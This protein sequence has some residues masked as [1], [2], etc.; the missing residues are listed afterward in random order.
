MDHKA[1]KSSNI[2][3]VAYDPATKEME[4]R[5]IGGNTYRYSGVPEGTH[6]AF[7][8]SSSIGGHFHQHI[9]DKFK[10]RKV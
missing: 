7:M 6:K 3:S 1:V 8:S 10:T 4:V 9:K 2:Q 5:F